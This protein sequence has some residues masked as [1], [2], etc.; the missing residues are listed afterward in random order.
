MVTG[1]TKSMRNRMLVI[2]LLIV[3]TA[4]LLIGARLFYIMIIESDFYQEKAAKQ[5]LYDAE[6]AAERGNI[7]DANMELLAKSATVWTVYISP[8]N[9]KTVK[10]EAERNA[11]KADIA[12]NL[13]QILGMQFETV[14]AQTNKNT[15]YVIVKRK[16]EKPEADKIR[17]YIANSELK[18]GQYIG[19][20]EGNKRYYP[21]DNLAASVLGF[22]GSDNQGLAGLELYYD[23]ELT[24]TPGRVVAAKDANGVDM[25]LSY[26]GVVNAEP[27]NSLVTTI[28]KYVQYVAEK[29]LKQGIVD[30]QIA[31]RGAC[32]VMNVN[33]GSILAL[34]VEGGFNPNEPFQLSL[35]E[36]TQVDALEGDERTKLLSDLRNRQWRNKAVS[37]VY[38]PGSVFKIVT[39]SMAL[40]ESVVSTSNT[41]NCPGYIV[42]AGNRYHCHKR[43][44]H[45]FETLAQAVQNSCNPVFITL[46]QQLGASKF[47]SYFEAFGLT[48]KTGIDLPGE[49]TPIYHK[50]SNMGP[51]ELA[52][53]SFGQTFNVSP[54]QM[55]TAVSAAVNGGN[56][57]QPHVVDRIIDQEGNTVKN[58]GTNI[59]RQVISEETSKIV[60]S[61]LEGVVDGGGGKN[62]Y[63]PGYRIG[64]KTGTSEK[65][66]KMQSLGTGEKLYISSFVGVAPIDEPEIAVLVMLDEPKGAAYYG[67]VVAAPIG[68]QVLGEV[69]PY[70]GYEP[71]YTEEQLKSMAISV[72]DV[73]GEGISKAKQKVKDL[74][75]SVKVI[76]DGD[77]VLSQ[78]PEG[79]ASIYKSGTVVLYT[80]ESSENAMT[81]VPDFKGYTISNVNELASNYS[82]NVVYQGAS[83]NSTN[84]YAY[85]Q[86]V[87][88]GT[89]V[90]KGTVVTVY[91]RSEESTD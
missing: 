65:V 14:L 86:S 12:T 68:G 34:A 74:G 57:V 76:G 13:S 77:T 85:R 53:S 6:L 42:I 59:K 15:S 26:E 36:Q 22:V 39:L 75:L 33:T 72:P 20:D 25:P 9:F 17:E 63:V 82:I 3:I 61:L 37:D 88:S 49:A 18:V 21:N 48:Q 31:E 16:V 51:T 28:D 41:Y 11:I 46:G 44:G 32:I 67:S 55:I 56:L 90:K 58:I 38:D 10:D 71:K 30:N 2:R 91:F 73:K 69:L 78:L 35:E 50:L 54:I 89:E 87:E 4:I 45:G 7:Y 27:G 29:Y 62:A 52:S 83:L 43:T 24:G 64:G 5:Q 19:L 70:L 80:V 66:S 40:E 60:C 23:S 1:P 81:T 47:S 84:V 79:N 8:N